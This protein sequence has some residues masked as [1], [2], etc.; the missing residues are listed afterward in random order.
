MRSFLRIAATAAT[1]GLILSACASSSA[2]ATSIKVTMTEFSFVPNTFT[3]PAGQQ[4]KISATNSGAVAHDF[5]IMK[6]GQEL[7]GHGMPGTDSHAGA[8]WALEQIPPGESVQAEFTAP[9]EPGEYQIACGVP[10]H[11]DAG[12]VGKLVVVAP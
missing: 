11:L 8:F 2:P 7:T 12:M 6:H 1:L 3:V 5:M 10:G 4:I 9:D